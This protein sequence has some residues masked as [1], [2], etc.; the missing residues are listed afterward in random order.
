MNLFTVRNKE[1]FNEGKQRN[2]VNRDLSDIILENLL[3]SFK[4][5]DEKDN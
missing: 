2:N 5:L 4:K 3:Y 1:I